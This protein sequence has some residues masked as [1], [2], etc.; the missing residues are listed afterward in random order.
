MYVWPKKLNALAKASTFCHFLAVTHCSTYTHFVINKQPVV[1]GDYILYVLLCYLSLQPVTMATKVHTFSVTGLAFCRLV[2][3]AIKGA[4]L[5]D[6]GKMAALS[7]SADR[8]CCATMV[9]ERKGEE[10]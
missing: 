5:K 6:R 10:D 9:T 1:V 3:P 7:V 8:T 2:D 4:G